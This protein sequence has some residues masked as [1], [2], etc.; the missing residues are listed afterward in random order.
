M[1]FQSQRSSM[2]FQSAFKPGT[3]VSLSMGRMPTYQ[4]RICPNGMSEKNRFFLFPFFLV[5]GIGNSFFGW[6]FFATKIAMLL[7]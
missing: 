2:V 4:K 6:P 3:S 7:L 1:P 5:Y